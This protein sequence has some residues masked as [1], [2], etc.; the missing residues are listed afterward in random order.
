MVNGRTKGAAG[1]REFCKW[2]SD[3]LD[4]PHA[5]R[6]LEQVRGGG[7][8][9]VNCYPFVFEIKRVESLDL[10]NAWIQC[11]NACEEYRKSGFGYDENLL[12]VVAFRFNRKPWEFLISAQLIGCEKGYLRTTEKTFISWAKMQLELY[13][14]TA[15]TSFALL[16]NG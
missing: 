4:I 9:I 10:Q 14:T 8:D 3:N 5:E 15:R 2:L 13:K 16:A 7:S 12:P 11:K 6:N 1:E